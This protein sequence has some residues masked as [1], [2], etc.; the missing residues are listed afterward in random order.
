MST[1]KI[2]NYIVSLVV[3]ALLVFLGISVWLLSRPQELEIQGEVEATQ[4]KIASKLIGRIDSLLIHKGDK[5]SKGQ[6]LFTVISPELDAKM[7]QARAALDAASAQNDKAKN[8]AQVE[9]IRAAYTT[10]LKAQAAAEFAQKSYGRVE[11]LFK[12]G[13]IAEQKKDET[14]T[15][16][17]AAVETAE[18]AKAIY[19]K[20]KNG[21]RPED[22]A[23]ALALVDRAG[24]VIDEV[25]SYMTERRMVATVD[26]EVANIIAEEGELVSAG[27][28]VV[29]IV[30]LSDIWVTFNLRE[31][32]LADIKVGT[33]FVGKVPG[34]GMKEFKFKVS[35]I[36]ALGDFAKWNATKTSGDFDLRTFEVHAVPTTQIEGFRPGMSVIVNWAQVRK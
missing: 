14:E 2:R 4:V 11:R 31:D 15:Q 17:K 33:E 29:T 19:E 26:G 20:A 5:V 16:M 30:K 8:G 6:V 10:W 25:N 24:G 27:Y 28:P 32:L 18:A 7:R 36:N 13:V 12:E 23:A 22:K 3:L 34:L 35:Y 9:D 1:Q 21:A